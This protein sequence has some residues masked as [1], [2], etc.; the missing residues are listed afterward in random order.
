MTRTTKRLLFLLLLAP[1]VALG[2]SPALAQSTTLVPEDPGSE[3]QV[4]VGCLLS[5]PT[6]A[7]TSI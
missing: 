5:H 2:A 4:V 1:F 3:D 7:W 6:E